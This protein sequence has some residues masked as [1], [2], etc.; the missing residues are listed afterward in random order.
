MKK[1]IAVLTLSA[2]LVVG[3]FAGCGGS[4]GSGSSAAAS[5]AAGSSAASSSA[6]SSA[7]SSSASADG[8]FAKGLKGDGPKELSCKYADFK[9]PEGMKWEVYTYTGKPEAKTTGSVVMHMGTKDTSLLWFEVSTTRMVGAENS[10]TGKAKKLET[11]EEAANE[12]FRMHGKS[13]NGER[14]DGE[15]VKIGDYEYQ[16]L[17]IKSQYKDETFLV[18]AYKTSDGLEA[19]V[20]ITVNNKPTGSA[21]T[22]LNYKEGL[23][24][25]FIK[26]LKLK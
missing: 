19:Y 3:M 25:D 2:V 15:R 10:S 13:T 1:K 22:A 6:A 26:S 24:Q 20:E 16:T 14:I 17:T 7:A 9:V 8:E 5:S 21:G 18:T 11:I 12:C 4:G 23:A